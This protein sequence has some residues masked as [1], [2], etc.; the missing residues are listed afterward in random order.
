MTTDEL[1]VVMQAIR[2]ELPQHVNKAMA[3]FT[4]RYL[5]VCGWQWWPLQASA[6]TKPVSNSASSSCRWKTGF[7]QSHRHIV[8]QRS[9]C[10]EMTGCLGWNSRILSFFRHIST[11][12]SSKVHSRVDLWQN[13]CASL[14][15]FVVRVRCR[16]KES[17]RSLISWWASCIFTIHNFLSS[18]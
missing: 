15:Y 10:W 9:E 6:V 1:K 13:L 16:R 11:R 8:R 17:S 4:M 14:L 18:K 5:H 3:N 12:L 2:E 7:I